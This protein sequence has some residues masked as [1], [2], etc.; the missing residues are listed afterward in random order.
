MRTLRFLDQCLTRPTYA[1]ATLRSCLASFLAFAALGGTGAVSSAG[2]GDWSLPNPFAK[3]APVGTPAWWKQNKKQAKFVERKGFQVPGV[4]GYFD[5]NGRPIDQPYERAEL[6]KDDPEG[7]LPEFDARETY[8]KM[9]EAIGWGPNQQIAQ[10]A[11]DEAENLFRQEQ[12][13]QAADGY[14]NAAERW[15]DSLLAQDAQFMVGE[16]YFFDNR[17]TK[18]RDAYNELAQKFPNTRHLDKLVERQW[19]IAQYWE[20]DYFE[21]EYHVPLTPNPVDKTRPAFDTIG[22]ALKT[23]ENIRMN[24][25]TGPRA[26]DAIMAAAGVYFRRGRYEDADYHYTLLREEYPRSEFQFEAHLLGL[27]AKLR[28]YQGPDY[29]GGALEEARNLT[30]Q[31]KM[32][33]AGRLSPDDRDRLRNVEAEINREMAMRDVRMAKFYDDVKHYRAAAE[34]YR[35]VVADYPQTELAQQARQRLAEISDKPPE[36]TPRFTWFTDLF[37]ESRERTRV[38]RIPELQ[39]G[40]TRVAGAQ[41]ND[42]PTGGAEPPIR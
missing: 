13:S 24:D 36:P 7:L 11:F 34:Y 41:G 15:P 1:A 37:P 33:F 35:K 26:D 10:Q 20:K 28:K 19:A 31:L 23:Y 29:D 30:T 25:P 14:Q 40:S 38:A 32:Q 5:Q 8:G 4:D 22:H 16:C 17:Y 42:A 9:K 3:D 6:T 27:Q 21:H 39:N 12:Y 18:S 2:P